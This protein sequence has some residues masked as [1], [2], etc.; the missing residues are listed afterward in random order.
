MCLPDR[1]VLI[2]W[3]WYYYAVPMMT[4]TYKYMVVFTTVIALVSHEYRQTAA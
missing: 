4:L 1:Y 3:W 2:T